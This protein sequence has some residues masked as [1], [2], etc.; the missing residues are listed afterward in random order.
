M[1]PFSTLISDAVHAAH[2]DLISFLQKM[3]QA[4]IESGYGTMTMDE[5]LE[6]GKAKARIENGL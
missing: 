3:V 5:L 2:E 1:L 6:T 4:G